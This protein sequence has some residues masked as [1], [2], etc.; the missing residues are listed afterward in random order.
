MGSSALVIICTFFGSVEG[1]CWEEGGTVS[2]LQI[3]QGWPGAPA[4]LLLR[5]S[6]ANRRES[7]PLVGGASDAHGH[8]RGFYN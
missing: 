6:I 2:L 1:K 4:P 3:H 5:Q 8:Q 7:L